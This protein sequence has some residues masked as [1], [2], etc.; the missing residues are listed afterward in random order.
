MILATISLRS[1]PLHAEEFGQPDE[2][3]D[4]REY[5]KNSIE[6]KVGEPREIKRVPLFDNLPFLK[7]RAGD[8]LVK[9]KRWIRGGKDGKPRFDDEE[10]YFLQTNNKYYFLR[11]VRENSDKLLLIYGSDSVIFAWDF[12]LANATVLEQLD[13]RAFG[14]K[15]TVESF[16]NL[17]KD[18]QKEFPE[19]LRASGKVTI[20][21]PH[22]EGNGN[23]RR[24]IFQGLAFDRYRNTISKYQLEI[25]REAYIFKSKKLIVGPQRAGSESPRIKPYFNAVPKIKPTPEQ[26]AK[27]RAL[28]DHITKFQ[29]IVNKVLVQPTPFLHGFQ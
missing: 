22:L 26:V 16:M 11:P 25:G 6:E 23:A 9:A 1:T 28:E 20:E 3:F 14:E 27:V 8:Q 7:L 15:I 19:S 4:G 21:T 10:S 29:A 5:V 13:E 12:S 2:I 17:Q 18:L 24:A